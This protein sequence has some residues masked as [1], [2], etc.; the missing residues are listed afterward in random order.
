MKKLIIFL[1]LFLVCINFVSADDASSKK[2]CQECYGTTFNG[3][4]TSGN[5]QWGCYWS[6]S[7]CDP[8]SPGECSGL[9]ECCCSPQGSEL[10]CGDC[11]CNGINVGING[12]CSS[13]CGAFSSC[14][15]K[16]PGFVGADGNSCISCSSTCEGNVDTNKQSD[17]ATCTSSGW[18]NGESHK[19][20]DNGKCIEK[21][22]AGTDLCQRDEVCIGGGTTGTG[23]SGG[24]YQQSTICSPGQIICEGDNTYKCSSDGYSKSSLGKT[25]DC[26]KDGDCSSQACSAGDW[27]E[28]AGPSDLDMNGFCCGDDKEVDIGTQLSSHP[29]Y[30]CV[31][32]GALYRWIEGKDN[33]VYLNS[34]MVYCDNKFLMCLDHKGL[35]QIEVSESCDNQCDFYCDVNLK[36][37]IKKS[38]ANVGGDDFPTDILVD[39]L[40]SNL[41]SSSGCCP[42]KWCWNGEV[43]IEDQFKKACDSYIYEVGIHDYRCINGNWLKKEATYSW[44]YK[45]KGYCGGI[46]DCFVGCG[47]ATNNYDPEKYFTN[48]IPECISTSQYIL[49]HYC[50]LGEWTS[51][52]KFLAAKL[53]NYVNQTSSQTSSDFVIICDTYENVLNDYGYL[54]DNGRIAESYLVK[55]CEVGDNNI[56]CSNNFCLIKNFENDQIVFGTT[57]NEDM[58]KGPYKFKDVVDVLDCPGT[59]IGPWD[60]SECENNIFY[61][62]KL[63]IVISS[64]ESINLVNDMDRGSLFGYFLKNPIDS[65]MRLIR[66][67]Q[68]VYSTKVGSINVTF[69]ILDTIPA[70]GKVFIL[71]NQS[72]MI[73]GIYEA[74]KFDSNKFVNY[75]L[76]KYSGFEFDICERIDNV[77]N[78]QVT[79][80]EYLN[81]NAVI[82]EVEPSTTYLMSRWLDL[83]SKIKV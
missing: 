56:D 37:W 66:G 22:G 79:K 55:N 70:Y 10:M 32:E 35:G 7:W 1:A 78:S 12:K 9:N 29:N 26:C 64:D 59:S 77:S 33:S 19:I 24:Q 42:E 83:T 68:L 54:L 43:C 23:T 6:S 52:T 51:R 45:T 82:N 53:V 40:S 73:Q 20:C 16:D 76:I 31:K 25:L 14:D 62:D 36:K 58:F 60:Y 67:D 49:D 61:N 39:T 34:S 17:I 38:Q 2:H 8:G 3:G 75:M 46:G 81:T 44:D 11:I 65:I 80:C 63:K 28:A 13:A 5:C 15:G 71:K 30:V 72:K 27:L 48:E 57:L 4:S 47:D 50:E 18:T 41:E 74:N 69:P 21:A